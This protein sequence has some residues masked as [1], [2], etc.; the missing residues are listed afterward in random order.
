LIGGLFH[1]AAAELQNPAQARLGRVNAQRV[2]KLFATQ[3]AHCHR[4]VKANARGNEL[5]QNGPENEFY[6]AHGY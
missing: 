5:Q 4:G 6:K 3:F 2:A 1:V